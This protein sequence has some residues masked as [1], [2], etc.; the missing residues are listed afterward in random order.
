MV[1][2]VIKK[3]GDNEDFIKEKIV[4][5]A[6]K[7]GASYGRAKKIA[8]KIKTKYR[9][10]NTVKTTEIRS[11]IVKELLKGKNVIPEEKTPQY[12][13]LINKVEEELEERASYGASKRIL[14]SLKDTEEVN[15]F[16][17]KIGDKQNIKIKEINH[18]KNKFVS[19][20]E[21]RPPTLH[22]Y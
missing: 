9:D 22:F 2:E 21:I 12:L 15:E 3:N 13:E 11:T 17:T 5:S 8:E 19:E 16:T 14:I 6:I 7:A 18:I 10:Q 4:V 1:K 20:I